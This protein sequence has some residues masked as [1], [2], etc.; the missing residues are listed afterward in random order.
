MN[1]LAGLLLVLVF[2]C[3]FVSA[4]GDDDDEQ[5]GRE[6]SELQLQERTEVELEEDTGTRTPSGVEVL[7]ELQQL[8]RGT[9]SSSVPS[10][11]GSEGLTILQWLDVVNRDVASYWQTVMNNEGYT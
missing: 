4:C 8:K 9:I 1:Q 5:S 6:S 3:G 7:N 2:A 11:R 10:I